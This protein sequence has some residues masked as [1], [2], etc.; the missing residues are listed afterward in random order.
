VRREEG[1]KDK[2]IL[3]NVL[4]LKGWLVY[5]LC[6]GRVLLKKFYYEIFQDSSGHLDCD[7]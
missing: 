4:E 7:G 1:K 3:V 5:A 2:I 6:T